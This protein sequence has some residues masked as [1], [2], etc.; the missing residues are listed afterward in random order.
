MLRHCRVLLLASCAVAGISGSVAN[1]AETVTYSY[2]AQGRL[3]ASSVS[4]GPDNGTTTAICYDAASNRERYVTA[5]A[6][7]AACTT[8]M[9]PPTAPLSSPAAPA[10]SALPAQGGPARAQ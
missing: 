2:D 6:G 8:S 9:Y 7:A 5:V 3:R 1:S 10:S 4:G